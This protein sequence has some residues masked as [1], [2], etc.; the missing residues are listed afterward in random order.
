M[1][2]KYAIFSFITSFMS[3]VAAMLIREYSVLITISALWIGAMPIIYKLSRIISSSLYLSLFSSIHIMLIPVIFL[4]VAVILI[5][6]GMGIL[7]ETTENYNLFLLLIYFF[8][9]II[10]YILSISLS[11]KSINNYFIFPKK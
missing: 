7:K 9:H 6:Y 4:S 3:I 1:Y 10:C 5:N 2:F 11:R 8:V